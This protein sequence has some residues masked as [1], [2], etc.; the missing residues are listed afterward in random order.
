[1]TVEEK[2]VNNTLA[3]YKT[4]ANDSKKGDHGT[5]YVHK[6][7]Q[8]LPQGC[9]GAPGHV[10]KVDY[11]D[12]YIM[13]LSCAYEVRP[14]GFFGRRTN[15]SFIRSFRS[16]NRLSA[17]LPQLLVLLTFAACSLNQSGRALST[18]STY[19]STTGTV[20]VLVRQLRARPGIWVYYRAPLTALSH[21]N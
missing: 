17:C 13:Q 14:L 11:E 19:N 18:P 8:V 10:V 9:A 4:C 2:G 3:P 20:P 7:I 1:M 6:W 15:H 12:V 21:S 5:W 16:S